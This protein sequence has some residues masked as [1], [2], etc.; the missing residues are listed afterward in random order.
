LL[1]APSPQ[2]L[3]GLGKPARGS[4]GDRPQRGAHAAAW[5]VSSWAPLS[6]AP[7]I[8]PDFAQRAASG[9]KRQRIDSSRTRFSASRTESAGSRSVAKARPGFGLR[10]RSMDCLS[11]VTGSVI[12]APAC[13]QA[14]V[15]AC[16]GG[17]G[18]AAGGG[19]R[20]AAARVPASHLRGEGRPV[21]GWAGSAAAVRALLRPR[22]SQNRSFPATR[23]RDRSAPL[24]TEPPRTRTSRRS[25]PRRP[26]EAPRAGPRQTATRTDQIRRGATPSAS[27]KR[28]AP[29]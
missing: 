3:A 12:L 23:Q 5:S 9:Y 16:A 19:D 10:D 27:S 2:A 26:S 22:S 21:G 24:L 29:R 4:S 6:I 7:G 15:P 20:R 13:A 8:L 11:R 28:N 18:A 25:P 1:P 17:L 14:L